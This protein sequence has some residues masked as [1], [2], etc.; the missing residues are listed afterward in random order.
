MKIQAIAILVFLF[1]QSVAQNIPDGYKILQQIE[2][3][4]TKDGIPEKVVV[5]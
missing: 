2:G 5:F 4:L 3:D 1:S